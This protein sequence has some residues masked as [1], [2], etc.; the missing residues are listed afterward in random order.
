MKLRYFKLCDKFHSP[1]ERFHET[2]CS[3]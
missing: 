2:K 3:P 1:V